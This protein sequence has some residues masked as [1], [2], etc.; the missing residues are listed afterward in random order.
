[1]SHPDAEKECESVYNGQLARIENMK[2]NRKISWMAQTDKLRAA[3]ETYEHLW[4]AYAERSTP[5]QWVDSNGESA[6]FTNWAKNADGKL[7]PDNEIRDGESQD[8]V[9]LTWGCKIDL[10][11]FFNTNFNSNFETQ[12]V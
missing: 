10:N 1:M 3:T 8:C 11:Y 5:G 2:Y 9:Y 12:H 4:I 6:V 7:N